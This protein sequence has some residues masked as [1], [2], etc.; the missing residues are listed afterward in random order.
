MYY[1][2]VGNTNSKGDIIMSKLQNNIIVIKTFEDFILTVYVVI[3]D[4][5]HQFA[6]SEVTYR[7]HI[8]DAKLSNPK[9]IAISIC[10][11]LA[12]IYS[13]NACFFLL[14]KKIPPSFF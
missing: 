10:C 5:Y 7:L 9:L 3:Y 4:L 2:F 8:L 11:E 6:P 1:L 13:E 14:S 12:G